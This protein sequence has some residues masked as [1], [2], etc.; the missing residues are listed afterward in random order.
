MRYKANPLSIIPDVVNNEL[1]AIETI[2]ASHAELF[3]DN[4]DRIFCSQV[5]VRVIV[6]RDPSPAEWM[7]G[8]D[9]IY[10]GHGLKVNGLTPK[11]VYS[12]RI[13]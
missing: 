13:S 1:F 12:S 6:T 2:N 11:I 4:R 3:I 7:A 8:S 5:V 10:V 9:W